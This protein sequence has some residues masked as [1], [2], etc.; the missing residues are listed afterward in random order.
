MNRRAPSAAVEETHPD[1]VTGKE[2]AQPAVCGLATKTAL[3]EMSLLGRH[4]RL[5]E[6][7]QAAEE[8]QVQ[9]QADQLQAQHEEAASVNIVAESD[10]CRPY[11][12]DSEIERVALGFLSCSLPHGEWTPQA[13]F[14]STLWLK[15]HL[16][17]LHLP[18]HLPHLIRDYNTACGVPNSGTQGYH[19]TIT[20]VSLK[21]ARS[22]LGSF[23]LTKEG[24][25]APLHQ[26]VSKLMASQLGDTNWVLKYWSKE[27]LFS[28]EARREWV[29]PDLYPLPAEW[30]DDDGERHPA[31]RM[32][33]PRHSTGCQTSEVDHQLAANRKLNYKHPTHRPTRL[34]DFTPSIDSA[35][36]QLSSKP[37]K[38]LFNS[39]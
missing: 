14:A 8:R 15:R 16:P 32:L 3:A 13:E 37:I 35:A 11:L 21:A 28:E 5:V 7:R 30:A 9:V 17:G 38:R 2:E 25:A 23:P 20:L 18:T 24:A 33:L 1:A 19:E 10:R 6:Q 36:D 31:H 22:F 27:V 12:S 26:V 4:K 34:T 29:V 39:I